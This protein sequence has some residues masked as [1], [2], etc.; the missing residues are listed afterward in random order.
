MKKIIKY[1][2]TLFKS[3]WYSMIFGK[4]NKNQL[5]IKST[6]LSVFK[7]HSTATVFIKGSISLGTLTTR[8]GELGQIKYDR[9]IVQL[10]PQSSLTINGHVALGAGVRLIVG[11]HGLVT[12]GNNT[13]VTA[14]SFILCQESIEIGENCAISWNVQIMDTDVHKISKEAIVSE[15]IKIGNNVWIG[16]GVSILK[17]VEIGDGAVIAA[18]SVVTKNVPPKSLF[19]GNPAKKIRDNI[20]WEL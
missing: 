5:P 10:E 14:N 16:S 17:G 11:K 9:A 18:G 15:P 3:V 20:E 1:P 6:W 12:I 7:K 2:G 8:F 4:N 19:G 13:F